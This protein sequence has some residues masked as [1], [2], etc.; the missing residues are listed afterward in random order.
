MRELPSHLQ[1]V[2]DELLEMI[3]FQQLKASVKGLSKKYRNHQG[4]IEP[5]A[6]SEGDCFAYLCFRFPA[7]FSV[8]CRVL[9]EL[10][11]HLPEFKPKSLLDF[12][13]GP[14]TPLWSIDEIF[15]EMEDISL[16]ERDSMFIDIGKELCTTTPY[17]TKNIA[18]LH[19]DFHKF[20]KLKPHDLTLFSYSLGEVEEPL[21]DHLLDLA[22][23]N[24]N[25]Y[26]IIIEPGTPEGF[27]RIRDFRN[28][29]ISKGA[30]I[31]APCP[32]QET[33]PMSSSDWCHFAT[34][35]PRSQ[36]HQMVK[37]GSCSYEDEKFSYLIATKKE[38]KP[39]GDRLLN[40]PVKRKGHVNLTLCT[41]EG[42]VKKIIARKDKE[43]YKKSKKLSWGDSLPN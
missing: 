42:I 39:F 12:G 13:S 19:R 31:V 7:T 2:I 20:K 9:A 40:S 11:E 4:F 32:H 37:H 43:L 26:L 29:L 25:D 28:I 17:P 15:P 38:M 22:L 33:C 16:I 24:T 30:T 23:A 41:E 27:S 34:R 21:W 14:G 10:R 8:I 18:W 6:D 3:P 36:L 1:S 35:L 5:F